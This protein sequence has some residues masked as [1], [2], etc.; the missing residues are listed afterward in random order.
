MPT[1]EQIELIGRGKELSSQ[2]QFTAFDKLPVVFKGFKG[3]SLVQVELDKETLYTLVP[4]LHPG[5]I[6]YAAAKAIVVL[7]NKRPVIA[8][9]KGARYYS[10]EEQDGNY[11]RKKVAKI[12][13]EISLVNL[14]EPREQVILEERKTQP[15]TNDYSYSWPGYLP[16][17]HERWEKGE[18]RLV[19]KAQGEGTFELFFQ[20]SWEM[21]NDK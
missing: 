14:N 2:E 16:Y 3:L 11:G 21:R 9:I 17:N 4:D 5:L 15:L 20:N 13:K 6:N 18:E 12:I 10:V 8:I 7:E 1:Q 19:V